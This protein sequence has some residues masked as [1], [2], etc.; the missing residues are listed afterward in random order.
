MG[1]KLRPDIEDGWHHVMNRG[2]DHQPVFLAA[3]DGKLFL[4]LVAEAAELL[5]VE[6]HADALMRTIALAMLDD[7]TPP[8]QES[9]ARLL[10]DLGDGARRTA[11]SR[12]RRR[13]AD[14]PWLAHAV[15]RARRL[16]A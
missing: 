11:L 12:A 10:G 7:A 4:W 9:L 2:V 6:V 15:D 13:V 8:P 5:G 14:E 3:G 1:R 16:A